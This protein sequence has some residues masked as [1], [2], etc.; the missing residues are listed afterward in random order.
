MD[1]YMKRDNDKTFSFFARMKKNLSDDVIDSDTAENY[2]K[3]TT[4]LRH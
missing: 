3:T 4:L 2:F 1:S